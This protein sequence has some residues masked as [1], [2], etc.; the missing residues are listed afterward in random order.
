MIYNEMAAT[1]LTFKVF[2]L[3]VIAFVDWLVVTVRSRNPE[4]I[5]ALI[6]RLEIDDKSDWIDDEAD[7]TIRVK[8][9]KSTEAIHRLDNEVFIFKLWSIQVKT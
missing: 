4:Q 3:L 9:Y 1:R 8:Q 5:T 6:N 2:L 7:L